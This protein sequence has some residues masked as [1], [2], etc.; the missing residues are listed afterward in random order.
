MKH[1]TVP[2]RNLCLYPF[3][4][5]NAIYCT[6]LPHVTSFGSHVSLCLLLTYI[7]YLHVLSA[8]SLVPLAL[9]CLLAPIPQLPIPPLFFCFGH[10][11]PP[12]PFC[13]SAPSFLDS[14]ICDW[15]RWIGPKYRH[16][17]ESTVVH[18]LTIHNVHWRSSSLRP[19]ALF[20]R[21]CWDD[22]HRI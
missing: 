5:K 6:G 10:A 22:A 17:I 3:S 4:S 13:C 20:G 12:S 16:L 21:A 19:M 2:A 15:H 1:C 11:Q 14:F 18:P 9:L 8:D 7:M